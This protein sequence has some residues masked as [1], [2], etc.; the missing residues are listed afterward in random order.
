MIEDLLSWLE[1]SE[2]PL[3]YLVLALAGSIEYVVPPFPGD[4]IVL[5]G[6]VLAGTARYDV[7]LVYAC[8]TGGSIGG[9]LIAYAFGAWI[10]RHEE[11]WPRFMRGE[12][13]RDRIE[14]VIRRFERHGAA[15]LAI[16]RF[17]PAFRAVF[18]LAAGMAEL[19]VWKVIVFGGLSA[20]VWNAG[21][22]GLGYALGHN[23]EQLQGVYSDYTAISLGVIGAIALFFVV[24]W[25]RRK[26]AA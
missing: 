12:K 8:I 6:S 15:Y 2:G 20:A 9:S 5:F 16:N 13:T 3:A 7:F 21:I 24:R 11:K 10:G 1:R 22:L 14:T 17:L 26:R 23:Y 4:T 18:F 25:L 19:P